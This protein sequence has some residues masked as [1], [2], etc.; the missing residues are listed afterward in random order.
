M[1]SE[2][3]HHER[4]KRK[5]PDGSFYQFTSITDAQE[6]CAFHNTYLTSNSPVVTYD[7][8]DS[9]ET[10]KVTLEFTSSDAQQAW[11]INVSNLNKNGIRYCANDIKWQGAEKPETLQVFVRNHVP[12]NGGF[13]G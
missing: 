7:L 5:L 1:S 6:K 13:V 4:F 9:G 10:L 12:G 2:F 8:E 11:W 3:T